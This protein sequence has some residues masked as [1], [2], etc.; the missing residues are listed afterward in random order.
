MGFGDLS[1]ETGVGALDDFLANK[2]YIEGFVPSQGD[3]VVF[4]AL[5]GP[6]DWKFVHARRWYN[7]IASYSEEEQ[8]HFV[9]VKKDLGE[10]GPIKDVPASASAGDDDDDDDVDLFGEDEEDDEE[11]ERIKE[12]R[13][14]MYEAKKA[15]KP[16]LIAKSNIIL[17]VKPWD[18]ETDMNELEKAVR[19]IEADG[20]RWG[21]SK[22]VPVAYGIKKLVICCVVEDDKIGT[23]FLESSIE[24]FED[25]VQSIDI[26]AFNKV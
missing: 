21:A 4:K 14:R 26:A 18:D 15:K 6:P 12:E 8:K 11:A 10:Y 22:F 17:D 9:G 13:K 3:L 24:A 23:E 16:A 19:S 7:Q 20:L 25:L 2:S 1:K 5:S